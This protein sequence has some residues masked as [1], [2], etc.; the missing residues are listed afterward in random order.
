[1]ANCRVCKCETTGNYHYLRGEGV[2]ALP[3]C[4]SCP[5]ESV[6]LFAKS[7][8]GKLLVSEGAFRRVPAPT[9]QKRPPC[10]ACGEESCKSSCDDEK[11]LSD[12]FLCSACWNL[13]RSQTDKMASARRAKQTSIGSETPTITRQQGESAA[14]EPVFLC[15]ECSAPFKPRSEIDLVCV[16][17]THRELSLFDEYERPVEGGHGIVRGVHLPRHAMNHDQRLSWKTRFETQT[18]TLDITR[19]PRRKR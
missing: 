12:H 4:G 3:W 15:D 5:K 14:T 6:E 13:G 7:D 17:C 18:V 1:M 11:N 19:E 8:M 2:F 9:A 16:Y 10:D